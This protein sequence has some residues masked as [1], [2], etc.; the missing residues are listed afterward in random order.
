M[1]EPVYEFVPR[2]YQEL[3]ALRVIPHKKTQAWLEKFMPEEPIYPG[4]GKFT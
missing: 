4:G 1:A 3:G 2:T